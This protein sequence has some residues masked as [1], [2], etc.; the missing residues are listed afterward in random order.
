VPPPLSPEVA[1]P[2]PWQAGPSRPWQKSLAARSA[3][4]G[5]RAVHAACVRAWRDVWRLA[6]PRRALHSTTQR[7][8]HDWR[9][10]G[11]P[12]FSAARPR[13]GS[14]AFNGVS[15]WYWWWRTARVGGRPPAAWH[16]PGG[17]RLSAGA[18]SR[19]PKQDQV[20]SVRPAR[21]RAGGTAGIGRPRAAG[22]ARSCGCGG[23]A[24]GTSTTASSGSGGGAP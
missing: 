3:C 18:G 13:P 16:G 24:G 19:G 5:R 21:P 10:R 14:A 12:G 11:I 20:G 17:S 15:G 2:C 6:R 22:R 9:G 4:M 1:V 8:A 7:R 23:V